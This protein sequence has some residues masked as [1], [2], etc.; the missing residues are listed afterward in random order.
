MWVHR[1][2]TSHWGLLKGGNKGTETHWRRGTLV[3]PRDWRL[4]T[5]YGFQYLIVGTLINH[6]IWT[7]TASSDF[8]HSKERSNY[9][10]SSVKLLQGYRSLKSVE[11]PKLSF[12]VHFSFVLRPR[13]SSV[14]VP[15]F[16]TVVDLLEPSC[17][18][19]STRRSTLVSGRLWNWRPNAPG[20][21]F[22]V[23]TIG[24]WGLFTFDRELFIHN[25]LRWLKRQ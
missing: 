17:K 11:D 2:S 25:K 12:E 14:G 7:E 5:Q 9:F 3:R 4:F 10:N 15:L 8:T 24:V 19:G 18:K 22:W 6:N 13:E 21:D 20:S 16:K 23:D 1:L